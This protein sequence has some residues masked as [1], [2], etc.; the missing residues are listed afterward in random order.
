M[1]AQTQTVADHEGRQGSDTLVVGEAVEDGSACLQREPV[2]RELVERALVKREL[3]K[4]ALV[5]RKCAEPQLVERTRY[6]TR[7]RR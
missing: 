6:S 1:Q 7:C 2:E 5:E 4:W 3:V